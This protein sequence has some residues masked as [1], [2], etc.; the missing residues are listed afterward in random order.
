MDIKRITCSLLLIAAASAAAAQGMGGAGQGGG[1]KRRGA[2]ELMAEN[3]FPPDLVM[4]NQQALGLTENQQAAIKA[5]MQRSMTAFT[6]LKWKESA[7]GEALEALIKQDHPDER[8][9]Q[10]LFDKLLAAENEVKRLQFG[11]LV[12]VKNI[13]TPAQQAQLRELKAQERDEGPPRE[14]GPGG[15]GQGGPPRPKPQG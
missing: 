12:R 14:R 10:A 5:E 7:A 6:D 9:A 3:L 2:P 4:Q 15:G 8:Q 11:M 1:H 13:L